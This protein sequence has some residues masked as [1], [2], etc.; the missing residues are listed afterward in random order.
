MFKYRWLGALAIV[1]LGLIGIRLSASP[2]TTPAVQKYHD[3]TLSS[4]VPMPI[5]GSSK[6]V[7]V[8]RPGSWGMD[9]YWNP[10][11]LLLTDSQHDQYSTF[12]ANGHEIS[13]WGP[14]IVVVQNNDLTTFA[15]KEQASAKD[16]TRCV[17]IYRLSTHGLSTST[18][19]EF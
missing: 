6:H 3:I 9:A 10:Y 8:D 13:S 15:C 12:L 4:M 16:L 11:S 1:G 17:K 2:A 5:F 18:L 7:S 19:V 14:Q